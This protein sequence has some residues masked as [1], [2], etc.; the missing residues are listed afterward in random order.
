[1]ILYFSATGN[2]E[3]IAKTIARE[4]DDTAISITDIDKTIILKDG[5]RL[6]L[7]TPT[8]FWRLPSIVEDFLF[9]VQIE[10][11]QNSYIF[12]IATYGT[13]CGQTDY[14]VKKHLK[15]KGLKLTASFNVKTVDNWTVLFS[16]NDKQKIDK[17]LLRE[18]EQTAV[19]LS[20]IKEQKQQLI[21]KGKMP[22]WLCWSAQSFYNKARKTSHLHATDKCISCNECAKNCPCNAIVLENG[23]PKWTIYKC[24]MCFKCLHHC[25]TFAIQYDNKTQKNGQYVHPKFE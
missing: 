19:I 12:Y 1:M 22:K 15:T 11:A 3:F 24:A 17:T 18:G 20:A 8:Y 5:E 9:N 25:P 23:K 16:V 7:I 21:K 6:G 10:N 2:C 4:L 13:T 14:Y